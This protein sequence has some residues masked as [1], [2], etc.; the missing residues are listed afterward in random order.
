MNMAQQDSL[1][2]YPIEFHRKVQWFGPLLLAE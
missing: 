2:V 1:Q